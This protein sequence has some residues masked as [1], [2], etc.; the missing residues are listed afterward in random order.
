MQLLEGA[1]TISD[2]AKTLAE[3]MTTF[4]KDGIDK[5]V[6]YVNGDI[7]DLQVRIEKLQELANEYDSFGGI[8][9]GNEGTTK[10]IFL[11]D[12]IKNETKEDNQ[13]AMPVNNEENLSEGNNYNKETTSGE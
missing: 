4:D 3:G 9:E 11:I 2:G 6:S 8:A 12:S 13:S 10:F 5:L 1:N 7:K